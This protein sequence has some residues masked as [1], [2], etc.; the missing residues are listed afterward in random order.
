MP[1]SS[2]STFPLLLLRFFLLTAMYI[3]FELPIKLP[4]FAQI[5][6]SRS[7]FLCSKASVHQ[8]LGLITFPPELRI[9]IISMACLQCLNYQVTVRV[10]AIQWRVHGLWDVM[11]ISVERIAAESLAYKSCQYLKDRV[12][13]CPLFGILPFSQCIICGAVITRRRANS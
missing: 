12:G 7:L 4:C 10:R 2:S 1:S 11:V 8:S 5:L 6:T 13:I 3:C 9:R